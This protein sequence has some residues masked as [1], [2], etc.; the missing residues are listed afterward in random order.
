MRNDLVLV[1]GGGRLG[2]AVAHRLRLC[3]FPVILTEAARPTL[4]HRSRS[5]GMAVYDSEIEVEN[6]TARRAA[7]ADGVRQILEAGAI[8]VLVD[9]AAAIREA[10][11][12]WVL[13]DAIG[14]DRNVG[15]R[16]TDA[17]IVIGEG[18]GFTAGEDVH[19]V[20]DPR[21]GADLGRFFPEG[22]LATEPPP[23]LPFGTDGGLIVSPGVGRF[24]PAASIGAAVAP[25]DLIGR[26]GTREVRS[27][28]A[29]I[30]SGLLM[31]GLFTGTGMRLAEVDP[32]SNAATLTRIDPVAR[33]AAGGVLEA[34]LYTA[35][36]G[37]E[38]EQRLTS[39][40][41]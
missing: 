25:G 22:A 38:P 27:P 31:E 28:V 2:T 40:S 15:T 3:G 4:I 19:A 11:R 33:A 20:V 23:W 32:A 39:D 14:L 30:L 6:V 35:A 34:A 1:R 18:P 21:P 10:V 5:F 12:P 17:P 8:P 16:R 7:G 26:V 36:V 37:S 9:P 41:R 13:V 24:D 29:G